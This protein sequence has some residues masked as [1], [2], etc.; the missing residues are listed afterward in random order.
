MEIKR[1][2]ETS[3][4]YTPILGGLLLVVTVFGLV[5]YGV[6]FEEVKDLLE[7]GMYIVLSGLGIVYP[8]G[9][10]YVK[11]KTGSQGIAGVLSSLVP[12]V[13]IGPAE[14]APDESKPEE[15]KPNE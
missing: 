9:R 12:G 15:E 7:Y 4:L 8:A 10:S 6:K 2:I 5:A 1:G 11:S 13:S 14:E 3:E